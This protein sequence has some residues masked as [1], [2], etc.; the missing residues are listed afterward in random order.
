MQNEQSATIAA[1]AATRELEAALLAAAMEFCRAESGGDTVARVLAHERMLAVHR[2]IE[3]TPATDSRYIDP[4]KLVSVQVCP[5]CC[6]SNIS[7]RV[8]FARVDGKPRAAAWH[9]YACGNVFEEVRVLW[10]EPR[11]IKP[12]VIKETK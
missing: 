12:R 9:C 1:E 6:S 2:K 7:Y 5:R 4:A 10:V 3:A 8:C 11:E